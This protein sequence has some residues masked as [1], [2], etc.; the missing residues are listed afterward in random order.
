MPDRAES[1]LNPHKKV[2]ALFIK[3]VADLQ[4]RHR[5]GDDIAD[6]LHALLARWLFSHIRND[7]AAYVESVKAKLKSL[8]EEKHQ[9]GWLSQAMGRFFSRGG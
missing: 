2:H 5:G 1:C 9:G 6:G 7:D 3:R 4:L 8:T